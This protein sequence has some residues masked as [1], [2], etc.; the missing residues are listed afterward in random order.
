MRN[1]CREGVVASVKMGES[2]R[3]AAAGKRI[4]MYFVLI[5]F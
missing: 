4:G 1:K 3:R 2:G 5:D